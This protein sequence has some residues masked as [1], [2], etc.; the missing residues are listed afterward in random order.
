MA[1]VLLLS[2]APEGD[3]R[4]PYY[5]RHDLERLLRSASKDKFRWHVLTEDP[6]AA[7]VIIFVERAH[8]AGANLEYVSVHPYT[9]QY[10]EKCF[11]CNARYKGI[12]FLPGVYA[13]IER[14]G[15]FKQRVRSGHYLEVAEKDHLVCE[16]ATGDHAYLYSF[17]G[18][19]GTAAVRSRIAR[20][21]HRRGMVVD[22]TREKP[23]EGE[24]A[25]EG[26]RY[27]LR[28]VDAVKKSAFV[29]CP[30]GIGVSTLRLF[31]TL[32]MGRAP[33][34]I[35][36]QWVPPEGP[37]WERFSLRIGEDQVHT[38]PAVLERNE[39][40]AKEMGHLA[41][42]AWEDWFSEEASFHRVVEWCLDI[43][44]KRIASEGILRYT[45]Y[46]QLLR[47][48]QLRRFIATQ[49]RSTPRVR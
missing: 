4:F 20:L 8:G 48:R 28:Y 34:I 22:T 45:A 41:R 31:E 38:I 26:G 11:V 16:P 2:A 44:D 43:K 29:L 42:A 15:Q 14:P 39:A 10:R 30:R 13:S 21:E 46:A 32:K 9:M 7:D 12:P 5:A 36:D 47:P 25:S 49:I 6:G 23:R 33:V 24:D 37:E 35:A 3:G 19:I 27:H 1:K 40:R 17:I 18:A